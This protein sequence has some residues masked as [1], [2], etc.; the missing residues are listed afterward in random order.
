MLRIVDSEFF[1]VENLG[2]VIILKE[3]GVGKNVSN[4]KFFELF[5]IKVVILLVLSVKRHLNI[6]WFV[7]VS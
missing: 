1:G 7:V 5:P 6:D 2:D 4:W 3:A